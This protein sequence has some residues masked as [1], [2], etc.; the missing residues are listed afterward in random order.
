MRGYNKRGTAGARCPHD[1]EIA[2]MKRVKKLHIKL[3]ILYTSFAV[4]MG[5]LHHRIRLLHYAE[6]GR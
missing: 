3:T 2:M 4:L 6:S 1:K 5:D